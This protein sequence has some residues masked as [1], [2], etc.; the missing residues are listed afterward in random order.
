LGYED[1]TRTSSDL[2]YQD[3]ETTPHSSQA[4]LKPTNGMYFPSQTRPKTLI[5]EIGSMV[6]ASEPHRV[7]TDEDSKKVELLFEEEM[8]GSEGGEEELFR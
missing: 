3:R 4:Q 2:V 6:I 5:F 8:D 7:S 1:F